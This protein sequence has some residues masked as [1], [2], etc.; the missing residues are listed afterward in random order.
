MDESQKVDCA[1]VEACCE[2]AEVLELVEA[3]FDAVSGSVGV[4]V[5]GDRCFSWII[6]TV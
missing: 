4:F 1:P 5:M 3:A 2:A 6:W